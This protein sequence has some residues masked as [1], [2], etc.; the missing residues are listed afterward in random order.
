M[1]V[2][3]E[4]QRED[5]ALRPGEQQARSRGAE[6][7]GKP[8]LASRDAQRFIA[9][10]FGA[11]D[12]HTRTEDRAA[13]PA[14]HPDDELALGSLTARIERVLDHPRLVALRFEAEADELWRGM[15]AH[16]RP[17]Q[18]AHM[19]EP[20]AL[21]DVW[22]PIAF[23]DGQRANRGGNYLKSIARLKPGVVRRGNAVEVVR[24]RVARLP[25]PL[26]AEAAV[27]AH[28]VDI[29]RDARP[30]VERVGRP[31]ARVA[32]ARGGNGQLRLKV[33][34]PC[35]EADLVL[36]RDFIVDAELAARLE[37]I[38]GVLSVNLSVVEA[39]RLA[40]VS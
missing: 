29:D 6:R 27:V 33:P 21:W 35:G 20:L 19:H 38:D 15:A 25:R 13:P 11:G 28:V 8:S 5:F 18:Y 37:R 36:G 30:H 12:Y 1:L 4:L 32:G 14:L 17:I 40:L 23:S 7:A 9:V 26:H 31:V 34:L 2:E 16:G 10:V 24:A 39:P 22:T 3:R